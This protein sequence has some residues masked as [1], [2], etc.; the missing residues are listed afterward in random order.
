MVVG[1]SEPRNSKLKTIKK[2]EQ[3]GL[4]PEMSSLF[5]VSEVFADA[6]VKLRC[7][8]VCATHK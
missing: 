1:E 7:S 4:N 3:I 5:S 2:R 6:K 8:E